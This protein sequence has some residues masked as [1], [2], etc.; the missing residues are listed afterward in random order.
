MPFPSP[1]EVP[2]ELT[3]FLAP[4]P[5]DPVLKELT[6]SPATAKPF[7]VLGTVMYTRLSLP[8]R[9]R[10]LAILTVASACGS[11]Y[12]FAQHEPMAEVNGVTAEERPEIRR[13][14]PEREIEVHGAG[15]LEKI[16]SVKI[17]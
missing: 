3:A 14:S 12:V 11:D 10:E 9:L 7:I 16:K 15:V 1:D 17:D 13:P 5:Q 2:A 6:H 8:P 4:L